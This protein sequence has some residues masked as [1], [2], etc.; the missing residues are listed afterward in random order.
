M[1]S[2]DALDRLLTRW[3]DTVARSRA[4]LLGLRGDS[5]LDLLCGPLRQAFVG[6]T[7]QALDAACAALDRLAAHLAEIEAVVAR[8]RALQ[9]RLRGLAGG[10]AEIDAALALLEGPSI[11]LVV[12]DLPLEQRHLLGPSS[13]TQAMTLEAA[14]ALMEA[15]FALASRAV[16]EIYA[17]WSEATEMRRQR[18]AALDALALEAGRAGGFS[19]DALAALRRDAGAIGDIALADPLT[20]H[21]AQ[22][23]DLAARIDRYRKHAV[24]AAQ[25]AA[26]MRRGLEEA[27]ARLAALGPA[28]AAAAARCREAAALCADPLPPVPVI[29]AADLTDWLERLA[30]RAGTAD[31]ASILVGLDAWT[32]PVRA[33]EAAAEAAQAAAGE[34]LRRREEARGRLMAARRKAHSVASFENDPE[35]QQ[36]ADETQKCLIGSKTEVAAGEAALRRFELAIERARNP[37]A[38]R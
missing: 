15:D 31:P 33:A 25:R 38:Q 3:A 10:G 23:D 7:A 13:T 36:L 6:T 32:R 20:D 26:A 14:L 21:R 29:D 9:P 11:V 27:A 34:L 17:A 16:A 1:G 24:D 35:L 19:A 28:I 2:A 30:A 8:A 18:L 12:E 4:A 37:L 5:R 22:I